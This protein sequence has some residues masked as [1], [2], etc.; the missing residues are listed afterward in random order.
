VQS[1]ETNFDGENENSPDGYTHRIMLT[2]QYFY[3]KVLP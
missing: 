2:I 1:L 3:N